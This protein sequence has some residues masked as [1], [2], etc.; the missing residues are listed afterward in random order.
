MLSTA[1]PQSRC[2]VVCVWCVECV[3]CA[4]GCPHNIKCPVVCVCVCVHLCVFVGVWYVCGVCVGGVC[5]CT[6]VDLV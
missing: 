3:L 1:F 2:P 5:V 4:Q 6:R